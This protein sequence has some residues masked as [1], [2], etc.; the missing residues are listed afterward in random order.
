MVIRSKYNER[1]KFKEFDKKDWKWSRCL[2]YL[3]KSLCKRVNEIR[4][5]SKKNMVIIR[6]F[7]FV[8]YLFL[9]VYYKFDVIVYWFDVVIYW[10]LVVYY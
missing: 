6:W 9:E 5:V 2:V 3:F 8:Y 4:K 7:F 10:F 1:K